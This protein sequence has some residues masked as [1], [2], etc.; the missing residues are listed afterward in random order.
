M[1]TRLRPQP[2]CDSCAF[3]RRMEREGGSCHR[4]APSTSSSG[5]EVAHW[6]RTHADDACGEWSPDRP[7][8]TLSC[9]DC[10]HWR[11]PKQGIIPLDRKDQLQDWWAHAGHCIRTAPSPDAQPGNRAF[12]R[13]T[14]E[15]DGC[16]DG[17]AL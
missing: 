11:H 12:W 1:T 4:R 8:A 14:H 13:A 2:R 17:E 3:W 9:G 16:Y 5:D 15:S 6:P 7:I 10:V